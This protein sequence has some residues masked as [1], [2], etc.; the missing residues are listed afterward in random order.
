MEPD[1]R[2][3]LHDA[4]IAVLRGTVEITPATIRH[5]AGEAF[6]R[7]EQQRRIPLSPE[8][9]ESVIAGI[10]GEVRGLGPIQ[11]LMDDP[12]VTE[13]MINGPDHIYVERGG[14]KTK[15]DLRF[16]SE[17][18]LRRLVERLLMPTGRRIDESLPYADFAIE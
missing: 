1:I 7:F 5:A 6:A 9:R 4:V 17:Q 8:L 15:T 12:L 11:P 16:Q 2:Q 18:D 3:Q 10:I 13:I 14:I